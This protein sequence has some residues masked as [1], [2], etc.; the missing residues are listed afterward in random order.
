MK[1]VRISYESAPISTMSLSHS[2]ESLSLH[3]LVTMSQHTL[4]QLASLQSR[5][6]PAANTLAHYQALPVVHHQLEE[7]T[8]QSG[9]L[10]VDD[11]VGSAASLDTSPDVIH[12]DLRSPSRNSSSGGKAWSTTLWRELCRQLPSLKILH[13]TPQPVTIDQLLNSM[14]TNRLGKPKDAHVRVYPTSNLVYTPPK[15]DMVC[16]H[17]LAAGAPSDHF[18]FPFSWHLASPCW[19]E[20][21]GIT[22]FH[23]TIPPQVHIPDIT[24]PSFYSTSSLQWYEKRR[25]PDHQPCLTNDMNSPKVTGV[26]WQRTG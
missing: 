19:W 2:S 17:D 11:V 21:L 7:A 6:D 18:L 20:D 23:P 15:S 3:L 4:S 16:L 14:R 9:A 8:Y 13:L 26:R 22:P 5:P 10:G 24:H 1:F 25:I 12:I